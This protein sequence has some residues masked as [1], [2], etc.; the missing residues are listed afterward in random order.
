MLRLNAPAK[1]A[2]TPSGEFRRQSGRHKA[3]PLKFHKE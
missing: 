3:K 2:I 1:A